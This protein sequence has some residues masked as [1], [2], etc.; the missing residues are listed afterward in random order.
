MW[1][2]IALIN[3]NINAQGS[4]IAKTGGFVETSGH[5]LF[6]GD[7]VIV[8]AKEWLLDPENVSIDA[9]SSGRNDTEE[10]S[11]YPSGTGNSKS[12]PKTNNP[13]KPTL[14]NSTL[15]MILKRGSFVNITA[16]KHIYVNSSINIGNNGHLI[17]S[18]EDKRGGI[19]INQDI[20][21]TGGS[22]TINSGGWV[23]VHKNIT[24]GSGF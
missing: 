3:G 18:S 15:E 12:D 2:D 10:T 5:D 6:I 9:P 17:L 21:S 8:D 7:N 16:T 13:S 20:T 19:E 11:E 23:D 4:D 24:L 14:T 22:L 1:G